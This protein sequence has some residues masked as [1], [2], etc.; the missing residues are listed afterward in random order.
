MAVV[1][2]EG[3]DDPERTTLASPAGHDG[4]RHGDKPVGQNLTIRAGPPRLAIL[5]VYD[6]SGSALP[7]VVNTRHHR[8]E[9][10]R[11]PRLILTSRRLLLAAVVVLVLF[12][13][14]PGTDT[15]QA[16]GYLLMALAAPVSIVV[17]IRRYR[18]VVGGPWKLIALAS[19]L[20]ALGEGVW[21][22]ERLVLD[23]AVPLGYPDALYL[24]ALAVLVVGLGQMARSRVA[25]RRSEPWFDAVIVA[26]AGAIVLWY[27]SISDALGHVGLSTGARVLIVVYPLADLLLLAT[28][29]CLAFLLERRLWSRRLLMFATACLLTSD[30]GYA[31][32]RQH[33]GPAPSWLGIGWVLWF[34]SLG[35]AALHPSM[36]QL[37]EADERPA[38]PPGLVRT[39]I[40]ATAV[41]L[42]P[43]LTLINEIGEADRRT[44]GLELMTLLIVAIV[45]ARVGAIGADRERHRE[46]DRSEVRFRSLVQHATD[47]ICIVDRDHR[48]IY[49]SPALTEIMRPPDRA[50]DHAVVEDLVVDDDLPR[51][52]S[53]LNRARGGSA[54]PPARAELRLALPHGRHCLAEVTAVDHGGDDGID[55]TVLNIR[56]ISYRLEARQAVQ[57]SEE[58]LRAAARQA[59]IFLLACDG[60]GICTLLEGL[61]L[62]YLGLRPGELVG[63][64]I[65]SAPAACRPIVEALAPLLATAS[66]ESVSLDVA[67]AGRTFQLTGSA[68]N[69]EGRNGLLAVATDVTDR[70]LREQRARTTARRQLV[71]AELWA[72]I[73][74][75]T[76]DRER[77]VAEVLTK[78]SGA[79]AATCAVV[80]IG[81]DGE[82]WTRAAGEWSP[83]FADSA[84]AVIHRGTVPETPCMLTSEG[85]QALD[86]AEDC[87]SVAFPIRT[88]GAAVGLLVAL[89]EEGQPPFDTEDFSFLLSISQ[90]TAL[91][92]DNARLLGEAQR[93]LAERRR[94]EEILRGS[95]QRWRAFGT[96]A[97]HQLRTP[98]TGLRLRVENELAALEHQATAARWHA[99]LM[100]LLGDVEHLEKT[101]S[102]FL[103]LVPSRMRSAE[104][105]DVATLIEE[106]G[107][108]W[109][110]TIEAMGRQ[111]ALWVEDDLPLALISA[112]AVR[113]VLGV[114]LENALEHG[115]GRVTLTAKE[116]G[117]DVVMEVRDEGAGFDVPRLKARGAASHNIGLRLAR[118]LAEAEGARIQVS[119]PGPGPT[120]AFSVPGW[121]TD[122]ETVPILSGPP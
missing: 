13:I 75:S 115:A 19:F 43:V 60:D 82:L 108:S 84:R 98:L 52:R 95:E 80:L 3:G 30:F 31:I 44:I 118:S 49:A 120:V 77:L 63:R 14:D 41:L 91:A 104:P 20:W 26:G 37:S 23:I 61:A 33:N 86:G 68:V 12:S 64:S 78:T 21:Y 89:R 65:G 66:V 50:F 76:F 27:L 29:I 40:I 39:A 93:E 48:L 15:Q 83:P 102:D 34:A 17:G 16:I 92:L 47:A 117:G 18:P 46:R 56:D 72:T 97:S 109:R 22:L 71:S 114:L 6:P 28:T 81:P 79:L 11:T 25:Q 119:N 90:R 73:L 110:P 7:V 103:S 53:L 57:R 70:V 38:P 99:V 9:G 121:A 67:V 96:E 55:G 101:V 42:G 5:H 74:N 87:R 62:S 4:R 112:A 88:T 116:M 58:Q 69:F 85:L 45:V 107:A 100:D 10:G 24:S 2:R 94:S 8:S 106:T 36:A 54:V 113:Q 59:P 32:T 105:L 51:L 35:A 111:L 122:I 1:D